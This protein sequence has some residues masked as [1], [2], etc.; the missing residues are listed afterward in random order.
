MSR[1]FQTLKQLDSFLN[2]RNYKEQL[3]Y[4]IHIKVHEGNRTGMR[5]NIFMSPLANAVGLDLEKLLHHYRKD[6]YDKN[7]KDGNRR[8]LSEMKDFDHLFP[9]HPLSVI[10]DQIRP[11]VLTSLSFEE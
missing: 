2:L 5:D 3:L 10:R 11:K 7:F 4:Q 1:S 6:P 9:A 8:N